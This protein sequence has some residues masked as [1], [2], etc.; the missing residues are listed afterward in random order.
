MSEERNPRTQMVAMASLDIEGAVYRI[1]AEAGLTY[2]ETVGALSSALSG[3]TRD[4]LRQ[5]RHPDDPE[6]PADLA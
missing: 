5:E 6:K 2:I 1:A 4:A 3:L